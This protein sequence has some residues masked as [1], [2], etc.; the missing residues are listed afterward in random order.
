MIVFTSLR[1]GGGTYKYFKFSG[2]RQACR[3]FWQEYQ[4]FFH[5]DQLLSKVS[6]SLTQATKFKRLIDLL[7]PPLRLVKNYSFT[8]SKAGSKWVVWLLKNSN[9]RSESTQR[10][11]TI[12]KTYIK[13]NLGQK[14]LQ[15]WRKLRFYV[16]LQ[17][18]LTGV[19]LYERK[20]GRDLMTNSRQK[21]LQAW[22]KPLENLNSVAC[23]RLADTF[24]RGWSL[25]T[26]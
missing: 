25:C 22:C 14:Y 18:L 20:F 15:A 1:R 7:P 9:L 13:T 19:G 11:G 21:Y 2:L 6:A 4:L 5:K 17:I 26:S 24:D 8:F 16:F 3:Y 23:V 12:F 10:N